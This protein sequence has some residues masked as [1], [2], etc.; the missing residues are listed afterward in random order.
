MTSG[1]KLAVWLGIGAAVM[2][3]LCGV[4][5]LAMAWV[6]SSLGGDGSWTKVSK[7]PPQ[8]HVKTSAT[9]FHFREMGF[10]DPHYEL[11]FE[12]SD[13]DGFLA[14]NALTKGASVP[15]SPLDAPLKATSAIELEGF[16]D[17][18]LYRSG[19]L[20]SVGAKTYAYLVAFGT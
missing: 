12:V 10:Q 6:G 20:W 1:R 16:V 17:D 9:D 2:I 18:Q 13:V 19:Q 7:A 15:P 3:F 11:L 4:G 8:F 5:V 14:D